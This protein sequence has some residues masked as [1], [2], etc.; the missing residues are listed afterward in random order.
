MLH[1]TAD[2]AFVRLSDAVIAMRRREARH[3]LTPT[4]AVDRIKRDLTNQHPAITA[5]DTLTTE[6]ATLDTTPALDISNYHSELILGTYQTIVEQVDERCRVS[7][8]AVAA[9]TYWGNET[10]DGWWLPAVEQWSRSIDRGGFNDPLD[11]PLLAGVR[12]FY[13]AG[14]AATAA[15]RYDLLAELFALP[16]TATATHRRRVPA[17]MTLGWN[18][19]HARL[20]P[21]FV[22]AA[23]ERF[24]TLLSEALA[25]SETR[26]DVLWQEFETLRAAGQILTHLTDDHIAS[27]RSAEVQWEHLSDQPASDEKAAA[28]KELNREWA[29]IARLAGD[30]S[31]CYP[32]IE[33]VDE[34]NAEGDRWVSPVAQ[35][36][37]DNPDRLVPLQSLGIDVPENRKSQ[38]LTIALA[39]ALKYFGLCANQV[40]NTQIVRPGTATVLPR[41]IWIDRS[42]PDAMHL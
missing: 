2:G 9:L 20:E 17:C 11:T 32:H 29:A 41:R 13:A 3:P 42:R 24:A 27:L 7:A 38:A 26:F 40:V 19:V 37:N 6:L 35:R 1:D 4:V 23:R 22:D 28:H 39:G 33:V 30:T 25:V 21:T 12:L 15:K 14:I 31:D 34:S 18:S 10:T 36:L 8:A 5:H 16:T